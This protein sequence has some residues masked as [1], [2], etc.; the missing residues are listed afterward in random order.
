[1]QD[2]SAPFE[3]QRGRDDVKATYLDTV[4]RPVI[5]MS[6]KN[7]VDDHIKDFKLR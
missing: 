7:L 5:V 6:K 1:M 4:G 3:Y 2:L